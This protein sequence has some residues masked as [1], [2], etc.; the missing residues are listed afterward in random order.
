[1]NTPPALRLAVFDCDG[2]LVDSQQAIVDA[3]RR[4]FIK[5]GHDR[6]RP[7]DVRSMVGLPLIEAISRLLP[8]HPHER[9]QNVC[10]SYK[11][12]FSQLRR[13]GR[14][15][16]PLYEG[17]IEAIGGL[18]RAGWLLGVATG[19]SRRGLDATI[20]THALEGR[21]ATLQTSDSAPAGKPAPDMMLQALRETGVEARAAV[22]IGDTTYDMEMARNAGVRAIGVAWGYHDPAALRDAG[23]HCVIARFADLTGV[24]DAMM[25]T[26]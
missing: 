1:M 23:A 19:K 25:E 24:L 14:V 10:E 21:F 16:E 15:H 22:M 5:H 9:H 6:P 26:A 11:D 13:A 12:A 7:E 18:E 2:T 20:G 3:M 17:A 8:E 4:A